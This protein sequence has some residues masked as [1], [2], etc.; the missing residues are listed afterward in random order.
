MITY[1][2]LLDSI[3]NDSD[4]SQIIVAD[5]VQLTFHF[6]WS[7][8]VQEL[9]DEFDRALESRA[10]SDSL[11]KGS[12][13]KRDYNWIEYYQSI[14]H[15]STAQVRAYYAE[16]DRWIPQ[17]L[18]KLYAEDTMDIFAQEIYDRCA[19]A[20]EITDQLECLYNQLVWQVEITDTEAESVSGVVR[21]GGWLNTQSS[22]WQVQFTADKDIIS[23]ED[24]NLITIKIEVAEV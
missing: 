5:T 23:R 13:L 16:E 1:K 15:L 14:P 12:E 7:T 9:T 8:D 24:L 6:V 18:L 10:R 3:P 4:F 20:E 11:I 2:A 17:S 19:E 21:T 22:K